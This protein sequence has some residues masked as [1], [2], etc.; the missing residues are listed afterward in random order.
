MKRL[1]GIL[2]AMSLVVSSPSLV[3]A[4]TTK[5]RITTPKLDK[6]LAKQLLVAI[7]GNKDLANIDFGSIFTD[8]EIEAVIV[9]MVNELLSLQYS[10][11][12]TNT[13]YKNLGFEEYSK[14]T[15]DKEFKS[16]YNI[17]SRTI[18]ENKLF[19][20]YTKSIT[21][22]RLDYWAIRNNYNLN[23]QNE[24][25]VKDINGTEFKVSSA[26]KH[27]YIGDENTI[28]SF[29]NEQGVE[30]G[31]TYSLPTIPQL[32]S[33][34]KEG[35]N[36]V[37]YV[38]DTSGTMKNI[39]SKTALYLRFQDY[40]ESKLLE[41]INENL[42][43]NAYLKASMFDVKTTNE[44]EKAPF[45]N[46]SS[47][48]FTKTQTLTETSINESWKTNVKMVWTLRFDVTQNS[49]IKAI[50]DLIKKAE[51]LLDQSSGA[52]K[53]GKEINEIYKVF[54]NSEDIKPITDSKTAYDSYFGLQG[55][56][57]LTIYDGDTSLGDS[58]ISG[59]TYES[60]VKSWNKGAG[61]VKSS[62]ENFLTVDSENSNYADLVIVLPIY[63]IELLGGSDE[64]KESY[65]K[66]EGKNGENES[67]PIKFS[68]TIGNETVYLDRWNNSN[69]KS[70]HSKD[71]AKL[72]KDSTKQTALLNQIMYGVSKS[73]ASSEL[74][75]TI[76]YS[77]YLDKDQVYY[78]G[79]WNK[80]GTYI[81]S[82]DDKDE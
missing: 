59:K 56:Q 34:Y 22:T 14:N 54:E 64:S 44:S 16:K 50:N 74:A 55:Y 47:A 10:Y 13:L 9:N 60:K 82:E 33:E 4:C 53:N 65:Y 76:I 21:S 5:E 45:I 61:I 69:N 78:A 68:N 39:S 24:T 80:I 41:E 49:N 66:I 43:T 71:V 32:T 62:S 42:L 15:I 30:S 36:S 73:S 79:L 48:M 75:K 67:A 31:K 35:S 52:L 37:F 20:D 27:V 46:S 81:K 12:A 18:A 3:V 17:E 2:G 38:K 8:A 26:N 77:K 6:E 7:S 1:L 11:D 72:A 29:T 40:F 25:D 28:W 19:E 58:P 51:G 63:M 23:I 57:G 70:L